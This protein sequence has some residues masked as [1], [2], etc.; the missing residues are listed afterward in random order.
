MNEHNLTRIP[1][2][3]RFVIQNFP[4][5]EKDFDALTDYALISKVIEFLNKVINRTNEI[6]GDIEYLLNYFDHLDIQDEVNKKLEDMVEDGTL[7][8]IIN[9]E[10]FNELNTKV[11]FLTGDDIKYHFIKTGE[12]YGDC[13]LVQIND[14]N[15]LIDLSASTT[16]T[17]LLSYLS[18]LNVTHI[19]K[20]IISHFHYDHI[21]GNQAQ[22]FAVLCNAGLI[23]STT[24]VCVPTEPNWNSFVNDTASDTSNVVG[25]VTSMIEY[26]ENICETHNITIDHM[27]T[28]DEEI[29]DN[30][31]LKF[32]NCSSAQYLNYY[33]VTLSYDDNGTIRYYT[34]YNNF[35][36]IV[37]IQ[38][39][40]TS[41]FT[42]DINITAEEVNDSSINLPID[43][44]KIPH[45]GVNNELY[46]PFAYKAIG[47]VN[48]IMN[49]ASTA[50][51]RRAYIASC[52]TLGKRVYTSE[53]NGII[54]IEDKNG[55]L[56]DNNE[57][58]LYSDLLSPAVGYDF[59]QM[60]GIY[61]LGLLQR[62]HLIQNGSLD[63]NDYTTPGVYQ[64]DTAATTQSLSN[65]PTMYSE[66][67]FRLIVSQGQSDERL[68]QEIR[69]L[70]PYNE[71]YRR[72]YG[73]SELGWSA[74]IK[75]GG[76]FACFT[77]TAGSTSSD[78]SIGMT[79]SNGTG[80]ITYSSTD[81]SINMGLI[82]LF[83]ISG[84][85]TFTSLAS[86]T[87]V[88]IQI[89]KNG[90]RVQRSYVEGTGNNVTGM[91]PTVILPIATADKITLKVITSTGDS[92]TINA[93]S[94]LIIERKV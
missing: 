62:N 83:K 11:D 35:S 21:G 37:M 81:K 28:G 78:T 47:K 43:I 5:I 44:L 8:E 1:K 38:G 64:S 27:A 6:S 46:A 3:R 68:I 14:K 42:G 23:D 74:W 4:F 76:E 84:Q 90:T 13:T 15:I 67:P 41:L 33:D 89:L 55:E 26:F 20:L 61:N 25:R 10:I 59:L 49:T 36:M 48:I 60:N 31:T 16:E 2:F 87:V 94:N 39:K 24:Q 57:Q 63:L 54:V 18:D 30:T 50:N 58:V 12:N 56:I 52:L 66:T 80:T 9:Q 32:L 45:H 85:I 22:G 88:D 17:D 65:M 72:W 77:I 69:T 7:A 29:V 91:I 40:R 79:K 82:G 71:V 75:E 86:G 70:S 73:G 53:L 34:D 19:D 51:P 93:N 92:F